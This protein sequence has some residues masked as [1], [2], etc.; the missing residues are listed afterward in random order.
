MARS[1]YQRSQQSLDDH[2][3]NRL[4]IV[5]AAFAAAGL[6]ISQGGYPINANQTEAYDSGFQRGCRWA[7]EAAAFRG[8][9]INERWDLADS[10]YAGQGEQDGWNAAVNAIGTR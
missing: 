5:N 1:V 3:R 9:T 7:Y 6:E 2:K 4:A 10:T 8:E